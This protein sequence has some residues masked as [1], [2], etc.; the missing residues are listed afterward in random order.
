MIKKPAWQLAV[1]DNRMNIV[2]HINNDVPKSIK[3]YNEE[4]HEYCG[5]GASTFNF[6]IDKFVNGKL[7]PRINKLT[8]DAHISFRD[9]GK[10][11][12]FNIISRKETDT[13]IEFEC[14]SMS[15]ELLNER[16]AAY[17]AKEAY[18][19][20]QYAHI[21]NLFNHTRLELGRCDVKYTKLKLKFDSDEDTCLARIRKLVEAFDGEMEILT[22]LL[23]TGQIDKYVLNVYKSRAL[24]KDREDGLG[25]VRTD[26]RLEM[27]RDVASVVK[28]EE[29]ANLFNAIRVRDK[30]GNYIKQPKAREI[31]AADGVHNEIYCT[32][33]ATTVFAPLSMRL[34]PSVNKRE[35][36]DHWIVRDVKTE[37]TDY[38]QAWA[39]CVKMLKNY[40]YPVTTW[41]IELNSAVVLQRHDIKIGDIIFL[42]DENFAGGLLIRARVVEMV[43]CSTDISRTKITLSNVVAT[44][45]SNNTTLSNIM[46]QLVADAQPFKMNVKVTGPTMFREL[47]DTCDVIPTLY[48]GTTEFTSVDYT[49]LIDGNVAGSGDRFTVSKANIGTSGRALITVQALVKGEVVEFQDITFSTVNDGI[50]PILTVVESSNGD[51]FKNN[52]IDTKITAR[53]YRNDE[54]I[55]VSGEAFSYNWIK[56]NS[57]GITDVE[58]GKK[59]ISHKKS[60]TITNDD[61]L[62]RATFRVTVESK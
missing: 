20:L 50:S 42:T 8:S 28:K 39:Y 11:Y 32:R 15:L 58:W 5:K 51:T 38:K 18:T 13:T 4:F 10:D 25:R 61:V 45:P 33:N 16:I 3:Y 43:R 9:D 54:E 34:Y 29:K 17:E 12:V 7:N 48:K 35:A 31:K 47:T 21:M 44:K 30:D 52:I 19:F 1:H 36:C 2:D 27:G 49:Y 23:P 14:N 53:L 6:T 37:F 22:Y 26:I 57:D 56:V 59:E 60:F 62:K 41:E 46:S 55:D 40:M 24:S